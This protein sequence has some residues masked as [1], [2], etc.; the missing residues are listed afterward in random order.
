MDAIA[1]RAP[2]ED[3]MNEDVPHAA[4][5]DGFSRWELLE[6][7]LTEVVERHEPEAARVLRGQATTDRIRA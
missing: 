3:P 5:V 1:T 2:R 7:L 4:A 6:R